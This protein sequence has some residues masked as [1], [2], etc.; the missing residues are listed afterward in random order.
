MVVREQLPPRVQIVH[1]DGKRVFL[2][3]LSEVDAY[4]S[5]PSPH[6]KA[7]EVLVEVLPPDEDPTGVDASP[8]K[9]VAAKS[10]HFVLGGPKRRVMGASILAYEDAEAAQKMASQYGGV[11]GNFEAVRAQ[12]KK[13]AS[14]GSAS[15]HSHP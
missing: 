7:A 5:A 1:R 14:G 15:D 8:R 12:L 6:G 13:D 3:A 11:V 10:A 4:L 9:W 2:C